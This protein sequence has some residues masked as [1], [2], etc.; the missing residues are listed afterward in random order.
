[1][2]A[3]ADTADWRRADGAFRELRELAPSIKT[4][5]PQP[6]GYT[7]VLNGS[8]VFATGWNARAQLYRDRSDGRLGVMLPD[9]GTVFQINTIN[10]VRGAPHRPA[11]VAFMAYALSAPAQ[12]AF[13]ER[14]YYAPTNALA[15]IDP[16]AEARTA[17]S[18]FNMAKVVPV[19][20]KEMAKLQAT[21]DRRWRDVIEAA[22]Q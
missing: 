20:W 14:M 15:Q 17:A 7:L 22:R 18:P 13:A 3:H 2:L 11:A 21:W 4:F 1:L 12:K 19:D 6:D 9:E 16:G 5:D 10:L 8:V